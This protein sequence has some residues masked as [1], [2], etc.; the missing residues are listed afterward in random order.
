MHSFFI[1]AAVDPADLYALVT[2]VVIN[3][4]GKDA[5]LAADYRAVTSEDISGLNHDMILLKAI[6]A[7]LV[8]CMDR[9]PP[10]NKAA[11]IRG[12]VLGAEFNFG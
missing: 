11:V 1:S 9:L 8:P 12:P 7:G 4:L 2:S 6:N 10:Q 3:D 5:Q